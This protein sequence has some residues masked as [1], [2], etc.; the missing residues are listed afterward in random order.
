MGAF[1]QLLLNEVL[2]VEA[3]TELVSLGVPDYSQGFDGGA[4]VEQPVCQR[5]AVSGPFA[6]V[7]FSMSAVMTN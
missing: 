6:D 4:W 3:F 1:R 7:H 2:D 5:L